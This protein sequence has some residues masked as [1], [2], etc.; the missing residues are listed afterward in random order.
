MNKKVSMMITILIVAVIAAFGFTKLKGNNSNDAENKAGGELKITH[1]LGE[2]TLNKNPK[3]V[4]VFD[5]GILDSLDKMGIEPVALPK[6]NIPKDLQK[7]KDDKYTDV[8]TLQEPNFEKINELKPDLI[9]ISA[10]QAKLYEEFKKIAPTVYLAIN[11]ENYIDSFN[12][13]MKT[14]GEIFGKEEFVEKELKNIDDSIKALNEK[15]KANGEDGLVIMVNEGALSAYGA[16]SR[17][18]VIHKGFGFTPTDKDIK[19]STHGQN[20]SFEYVAEKNPDYLFVIDRGAAIGGDS[21]AKQVL[22]NDLI[23]TTSAYKNN[24]IV[25]LDS[26]IWYVATGGFNTT[27]KMINEVEASVK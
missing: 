19:S 6:S 14:L 5:Y 4:V 7:Y 23:K 16:E 3:K 1:E 12:S 15:V 21:T 2:T 8:G 26:E 25:Y 27:M 17:F 13:N 20:V 18:G 10:R 24:K 11:N 22:D 9:I